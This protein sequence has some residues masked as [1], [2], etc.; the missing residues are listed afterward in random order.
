MT[1]SFFHSHSSLVSLFW[2]IAGDKW[3]PRRKLLTPAFHFKI[4]DEFMPTF[5]EKSMAS[6]A[7]MEEILGTAGSKEIDVFSI[8]TD[9][10]FDVFCG[11]FIMVVNW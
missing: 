4:L 3:R 10:V 2:Y 7:K 11:N 8:M 1:L 6:V 9:P 5:N